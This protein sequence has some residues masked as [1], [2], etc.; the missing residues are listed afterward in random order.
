MTT[1]LCEL[2]CEHQNAYAEYWLVAA[3]NTSGC[4]LHD[5]DRRQLNMLLFFRIFKARDQKR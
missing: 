5:S 1:E 4:V 2:M 3:V